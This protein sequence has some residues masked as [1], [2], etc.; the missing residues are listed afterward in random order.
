MCRNIKN[1]YNF[2]PPATDEEIYNAS[3][4]FVRK[5]S[6]ITTPS[7]NNK[8]VF[9]QAVEE[10]SKV[11]KILLSSLSTNSK[12]KNREEELQKARERNAKRVSQ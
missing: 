4:Q 9:H 8:T 10:N 1:L 6:G 5:V 12:Q 2:D 7:K 3:L 11:I